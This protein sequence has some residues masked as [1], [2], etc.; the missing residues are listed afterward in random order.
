MPWWSYLLKSQGFDDNDFELED[1]T[2]AV[3]ESRMCLL[4]CSKGLA[5]AEPRERQASVKQPRQRQEWPD[6]APPRRP[7][8]V[9]NPARSC[10]LT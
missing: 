6:P 2:L 10:R 7:L 4:V 3:A 5:V 9:R 8:Y 1:C